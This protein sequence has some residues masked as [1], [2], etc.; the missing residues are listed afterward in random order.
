M[1]GRASGPVLMSRSILGCSEPK[2]VGATARGK[3][4]LEDSGV[5]LRSYGMI[6]LV[7]RQAH[8]SNIQGQRHG[9]TN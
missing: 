4:S 9:R 2:N 1:N 3:V 7:Y 6:L 5:H 8:E